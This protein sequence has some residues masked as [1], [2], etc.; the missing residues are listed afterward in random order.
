MR[1]SMTAPGTVGTVEKVAGFFERA[2]L[3][4]AA[5]MRRAVSARET[6]GR[7]G[8]SPAYDERLGWGR[9]EDYVDDAYDERIDRG[10]S[11]NSR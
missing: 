8:R 10:W 9:R 4:I 7:R 2:T 1:E 11:R 3:R 5:R 6:R